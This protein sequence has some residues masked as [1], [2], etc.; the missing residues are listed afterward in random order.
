[1][2]TIIEKFIVVEFINATLDYPQDLPIPRKGEFIRM[3]NDYG[4]VKTVT[5]S[6]EKTFKEVR[7]IVK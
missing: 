5:Y 7:I 2:K 1:M 4:T 6:I 3:G